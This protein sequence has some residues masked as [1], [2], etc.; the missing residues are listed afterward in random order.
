MRYLFSICLCLVAVSSIAQKMNSNDFFTSS[1]DAFYGQK[2]FHSQTLSGSV[3]SI[4]EAEFGSPLSFVGFS[5]TTVILLNRRFYFPC[6]SAFYHVLPQEIQLEDSISGRVS[7]FNFHIPLVGYDVFGRSKAFDL[8]LGA[9]F[10]TG[11]IRLFRDSR[12]EQVNAYFAPFA[13]I[14]PRV[15]LGRFSLQVRAEY[16]LDITRSKWRK[17]WL[18]NSPKADLGAMRST[19]LSTS[20][21]FGWIIE[22]VKK[23]SPRD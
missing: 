20:V 4:Q 19:G 2:F 22:D 1:F 3:G 14:S 5:W 7:G 17:V 9:G 10:N 8:V 21:S 11:R 6:T 15:K 16:E 18:S 13:S 23:R 12:I